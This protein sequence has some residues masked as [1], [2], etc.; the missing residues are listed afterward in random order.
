MLLEEKCE[1]FA[2]GFFMTQ[3]SAGGFSGAAIIAD[4]YGRAIGYIGGNLDAC[5]AANS[6]H[7]S[8]GLRFDRIMTATNR[9]TTH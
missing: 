9:R 4:K 3:L 6:Q 5:K 2:G 1:L 7:Q 8:Y